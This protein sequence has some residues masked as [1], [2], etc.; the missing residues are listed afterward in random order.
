MMDSLKIY[1]DPLSTRY[2]TREMAALWSA[3]KRIGIWRRLWVALAEAQMELGL[4]TADGA[5]PRI[6]P[7]QIEALRAKVDEIDFDAAETYER[8]FRHDVMAHI[9]AFGDVV[10]EAKE[11]I[12]LGATSCFVTDN[13]EVILMRSGMKLI[14]AQLASVLRAL[15]DFA[16]AHK[17]RICLGF[18]HFQPAQLTTIGKRACLWAQDFLIDLVDLEHRL[19]ELRFRGTK[20]TTG[21]QASF[22]ALFDGNHEKVVALDRLVAKKMGFD[23]IWPVTGQT[24]PRKMDSQILAALGGICESAHRF[25]ND[26]RLLSHRQELDEPFEDSQIGSSAMPYKRNPMRAERMCGLARYG[27]NLPGN[28]AQTAAV[29]WLERTL[30]DSVNRRLSIPQAFLTADSVLKLA[31]NI[32]RGMK[33]NP[34]VIQ[35][36]V[37]RI[38]PYMLT[39]N[40]MMAAVAQG[41]D[42]Q[43]LHEMIRVHSHAVTA[44]LKGGAPK[45][46]LLERLGSEK[47]FQGI[48]FQAIREKSY[49]AG[50]APEQVIDFLKEELEPKILKYQKNWALEATVER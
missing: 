49:L 34:E 16:V 44:A 18:T 6:R 46:D 36:E 2:A 47:A 48:D 1:E 25:G 50:R 19:S 29:Q 21:T 10:P 3:Q 41:G 45:N 20:G 27:M 24:Y 23:Q 38:M 5:T 39:E 33:P 15:A 32:A 42:R 40:L 9:H 26:L 35:R 14:C 7:G 4:K 8:K 30:D 31:L 43:E 12:H 37:D 11:I 28:A 22:M 17:D 13:A